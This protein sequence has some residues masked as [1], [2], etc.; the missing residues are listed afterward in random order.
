MHAE[1]EEIMG[2]HR[3]ETEDGQRHWAQGLRIPTR[4][5]LMTGTLTLALA[6][7]AAALGLSLTDDPAPPTAA[8]STPWTGERTSYSST[9]RTD[10]DSLRGAPDAGRGQNAHTTTQTLVLDE[11]TEPAG[12]TPEP[13]GAVLGS[14]AEDVVVA[15]YGSHED[16]TRIW[17]QGQHGWTPSKNLDL[18]SYQPENAPETV[19]EPTPDA[20]AS[21]PPQGPEEAGSTDEAVTNQGPAN[22]TV[23]DT[24]TVTGSGWGHGV[25]MSQYGA[26][27]MARNG[28]THTQ[29]LTQ[30]YAPAELASRD[31]TREIR[32]H[33]RSAGSLALAGAGAITL[34]GLEAQGSGVSLEV[35]GSKVSATLTGAAP[36]ENDADLQAAGSRVKVRFQG[37]VTVPGADGGSR[38]TSLRHG[39]LEIT[40]SGGQLDVVAVMDVEDY[41]YGLA[42]V[43]SSWPAAALQAQAVAARTYALRNISSGA[44]KGWDVTD[45][46]SSQK[47][48]GLAKEDGPMGAQWK[49][50]VNATAGTVLLY[51]GAPIDAVYHSSSGGHTRSSADVW[52]GSVPYLAARPDPWTLDA[53]A[54]NPHASWTREV[55]QQQMREA[56]GTSSAITAVKV[57]K[58][59]DGAIF[60]ATATLVDG[61]GISLDG[62]EFRSAAGAKSAWVSSVNGS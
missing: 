42:E 38:A 51:Q 24:F 36:G 12:D 1:A 18:P 59:G 29:I 34:D 41:L 37:T 33:L 45:E 52:G 31:A 9:V 26:A 39:H 13:G 16:H 27:A 50:A 6:A 58:A 14:V 7:G 20:S 46:T 8:V 21:T 48:T 25:G 35:E 32:V 17:F 53:S 40:A 44:G 57:D 19:P 23:P 5:A 4:N 56:F 30:Y 28:Y 10:A 15:T 61:S 62:K 47:Y 60:R 22:A 49:A 54:G 43:P 55:S 11:A 3:A 2:R